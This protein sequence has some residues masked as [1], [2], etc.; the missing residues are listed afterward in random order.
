[1]ESKLTIGLCGELGLATGDQLQPRR[2]FRGLEFAFREFQVHLEVTRLGTLQL[3]IK[4]PHFRGKM[5]R[6]H[7]ESFAGSCLD[8]G[9]HDHQI[10]LAFWLM[11]AHQL[12]QL[13]GIAARLDASMRHFESLHESFDLFKVFQLLARQ[14]RQCHGE[15][16][17]LRVGKNQRES[18]RGCLLLA[19]CVIDEEYRQIV[20]RRLYPAAGRG[21]TQDTAAGSALEARHGRGFAPR[22]HVAGS[23][24]PSASRANSISFAAVSASAGRASASLAINVSMSG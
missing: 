3:L 18:G 1:M 8:Q 16:P 14:A 24:V 22:A 6:K 12:A 21:G 5:L 15:R 9:V 23:G 19:I 7:P 13:A 11:S 20:T 2:D 10:E 17:I 4:D